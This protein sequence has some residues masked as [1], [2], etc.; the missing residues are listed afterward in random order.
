[1]TKDPTLV[2]GASEGAVFKHLKTGAEIVLVQKERYGNGWVNV[3]LNVA[4]GHGLGW[5]SVLYDDDDPREDPPLRQREA[6]PPRDLGCRRRDR[7]KGV[8]HGGERASRAA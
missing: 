8:R 7:A 4:E 3:Q 6:W 1:M 2:A 5:V